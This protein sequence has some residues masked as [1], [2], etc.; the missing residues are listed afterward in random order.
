[1][2]QK[3]R[4]ENA[5]V[6]ESVEF[7]IWGMGPRV[8]ILRWN[9]TWGGDGRNTHPSRVLSL[10]GTRD[11]GRDVLVCQRYDFWG[12]RRG[13]VPARPHLHYSHGGTRK[14]KAWLTGP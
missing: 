5:T 7:R 2:I 4:K 9:W 10:P 1:M 8:Y 6:A 13:Y 3:A 11:V 14:G 12:I